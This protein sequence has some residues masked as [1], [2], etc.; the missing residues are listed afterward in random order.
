MD[1]TRCKHLPFFCPVKDQPGVC[2]CKLVRLAAVRNSHLSLR[3]TCQRVAACCYEHILRYL[4]LQYF[5]IV[6]TTEY[7]PSI[8][9]ERNTTDDVRELVTRNLC[10]CGKL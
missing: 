8:H 3:L 10:A 2:A 6:I 1:S 7:K 4:P 5:V 9:R